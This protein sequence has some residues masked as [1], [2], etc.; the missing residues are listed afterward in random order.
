ME[1]TTEDPYTTIRIKTSNKKKL[2]SLRTETTQSLSCD[3]L[4]NILL[5]FAFPNYKEKETK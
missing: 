1:E 2:E 5:T 3:D 4:L